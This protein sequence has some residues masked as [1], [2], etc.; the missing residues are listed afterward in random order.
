MRAILPLSFLFLGACQISHTQL[1]LPEGFLALEG[2]VDESRKSSATLGL[3]LSLNDSGSLLSLDI[4]PGCRVSSVKESSAADLAGI[5]VGDV[6]LAFEG[7]PTDDPERLSV[8]L[9]K[10]SGG[11]E[12]TLRIQRGSEVLEV[13]AI[14]QEEKTV[15]AR[16]LFWVERA[17]LRAAFEDGTSNNG[18][19]RIAQLAPSSPLI[20][21]G[22]KQGDTVESF[23][24]RDP[25]SAAEFVR[26][27]RRE[28]GP[29]DPFTLWVRSSSGLGRSVE[30]NAWAPE[31]ILTE[32][33]MWPLFSWDFDVGQDRE[34][35][36]IGDLVLA[37]LFKRIREG[38]EN[39]WS[40][41]SVFSW[42]TGR[43]ELEDAYPSV[44]R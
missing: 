38:G 27:V 39:R 44:S 20:V 35:L 6:L 4:Q 17:L 13:P 1:P 32:F 14:L 33:R 7:I 28:L 41:C 19:P 31:K 36:I 37:S 5:G 18:F 34:V 15:E 12:V 23:Q 30:G 24:G 26:R 3:A 10:R 40:I 25:G 22:V 8:L 29:G 21:A 42:R 2:Q 16:T 9:R 43:P 11:E